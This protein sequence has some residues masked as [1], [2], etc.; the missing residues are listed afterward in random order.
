MSKRG[1]GI[2]RTENEIIFHRASI[3]KALL[4]CEHIPSVAK[5]LGISTKTAYK[6][7]EEIK[8]AWVMEYQESTLALKMQELQKLQVLESEV[9]QAWNRSI[10]G[11]KKTRKTFRPSDEHEGADVLV[12]TVEEFEECA[13]DPR[14]I[15]EIVKCINKRAELLGLN[16]EA[17]KMTDQEMQGLESLFDEDEFTESYNKV[18]DAFS[19]RTRLPSQPSDTG[20]QRT[21]ASGETPA[22]S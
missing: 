19:A 3:S 5:R 10:G 1:S 16:R 2:S 7:V 12:S 11:K 9:W 22:T 15:S 13:G 14:Y 8:K 6:D 17:E 20:Q 18:I 21:L 4:Q